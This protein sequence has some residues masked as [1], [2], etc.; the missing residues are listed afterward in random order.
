MPRKGMEAPHIPIHTLPD[1]SLLALSELYL[2]NKSGVVSIFWSVFLS[3]MSSSKLL[4]LV[5]MG[6]PKLI[7]SRAK[8]WVA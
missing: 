4:N 3:S 8:M 7:A 5:F 2:Y 6:I 1:V